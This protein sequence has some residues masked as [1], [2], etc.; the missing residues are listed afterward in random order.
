MF[1]DITFDTIMENLL[2]RVPD[3]LDKREGAIIYDALAP[4]AVELQNA[5]INMDMVV[6][7]GF[8]NTASYAYL[9]KRAAEKGIYPNEATF[10]VRK[11]VFTPSTL[12]IDMGERFNLDDLNYYVKEKVSDGVYKLVCENAGIRGNQAFGE[13][14][15]MDYIEGLETAVLSDVLIPGEDEENVEVFRNRYFSSFSSVAFGGNAADYIEKVSS[16]D[17]VGGVKV[18]PTWNG[19]GTVKLVVISS[20]YAIPSS[21]LIQTVQLAIDPQN[22]PGEGKGIAPIGHTVTVFGVTGVTINI[23]AT[24]TYKTGF[25]YDNVKTTIQSVIDDY[26]LSLKEQ[27]QN[28]TTLVI[29]ISQIETKLLSIDGILDVSDVT[30]NTLA[31]NLELSQTQ[32]PIRG[33]FNGQ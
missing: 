21:D 28:E 26:Y 16:L 17:G 4:A 15:P 19:G 33:T 24:L 29:R 3:T 32:I 23:T 22:Y 14:I 12:E 10:A 20:D 8:A 27:W 9:I 7:E 11:G 1:E 25:T 30:I 2:S 31:K 6:D 13:L 5:Y 18:F